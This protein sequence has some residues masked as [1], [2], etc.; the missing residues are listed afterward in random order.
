MWVSA[1]DV[2]VYNK[3]IVRVEPVCDLRIWAKYVTLKRFGL[4]LSR[5][6]VCWHQ[7][8]GF[9][10]RSPSAIVQSAGGCCRCHCLVSN[11]DLCLEMTT[12]SALLI[13][14]FLSRHET[15]VIARLVV[16]PDYCL[17]Y[18]CIL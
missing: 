6:F 17:S 14:E 10:D 3:K 12:G 1:N 15:A 4:H 13:H 5:P 7:M 9:L 18:V 8:F 11:S 2:A 16:T